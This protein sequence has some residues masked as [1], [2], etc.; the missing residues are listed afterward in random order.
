MKNFKT[1]AIID[2]PLLKE[3]IEA[4]SFLWDKYTFRSSY[5]GSAH[6]DTKC[7]LLRNQEEPNTLE[8]NNET[9]CV[10]NED[11]LYYPVVEDLL[12]SIKEAMAINEFGRIMLVN[13]LH[14]GKI[15][16]HVD[17][18]LYSD[19]YSRVHLS[20]LSKTGNIFYCGDESKH[21]QEG[22]ICWFNHKVPHRVENNSDS[23]RIH[24]IIDYI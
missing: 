2:V 18:G 14:N 9:K 5:S 21:I 1:I 22:E 23:D 3:E 20:I 15:T 10:W 12:S 19:T 8:A 24:L 13:L 4:N 7:I 6:R 11:I 16:E 17:E